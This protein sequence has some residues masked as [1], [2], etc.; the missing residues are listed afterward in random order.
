M[1]RTFTL[2]CYA[3]ILCHSLATQAETSLSHWQQA[4][5]DWR[6]HQGAHINVLADQQPAFSALKP[7]L[8]L[9]EELTGISVGFHAL[10]Q[11][12]MRHRRTADLEKGLGLYD[13]LPMGVTFL[14]QAHAKG[15]LAPLT[16]Y[17]EN[18]TLTDLDWYKISDISRNSLALSRIDG[19]LLSLPF[20]FS[21]PIYFYR[22]DLFTEFDLA[23]PDTYE[24]L[25]KTKLALQHA[26][27]TSPQ[28]K[29]VRAFAARTLPGAGLNTWTI[30][31]IIRAYGGQ[32]ITQDEQATSNSQA[33]RTAVTLY[34]DL[35]TGYGN[36]D[37]SQILH[38][39]QIRELF[40]QGKLA[41][42]IIASH[43]YNEID[44]PE[45]SIIWDKWEAAPLPKGPYSRETSPWAWSF[46]INA[47]SANKSA[48]WL[49]IQWAT[50][51][52][53]A[54]L[55]ST[56]GSP[57]RQQIWQKQLFNLVNKPGFNNTMLWVFEHATPS[58]IQSGITLFPEIGEIIS[59]AYSQIFYGADVSNT[60]DSSNKKITQLLNNKKEQP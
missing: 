20:D 54:T 52:Q 37:N 21:A 40:K 59:H 26:L 49:F 28:H 57:P 4:K 53:T 48:A 45:E 18:P 51:E 58:Y 8:P 23:V 34:R 14:G 32:I 41:S 17:L 22:K 9:F 31:P 10:E 27:D 60:L 7:Y 47:K 15:Y 42:A 30:L 56:G 46:A 39:Y 6:A 13:V 1:N 16:P 44:T 50:S 25:L 3:F 19:T 12:K 35:V 36:P 38:F 43:F 33:V 11:S 24:D 5:I 55:L 2:L 29:G